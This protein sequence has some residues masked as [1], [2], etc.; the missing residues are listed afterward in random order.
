MLGGICS[1][2]WAALSGFSGRGCALAL[3]R[4]EVGRITTH[5]EEIRSGSKQ[6]EK[7]INK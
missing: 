4:L 3:L 2:I 1:T 6:D 5:S 7:R